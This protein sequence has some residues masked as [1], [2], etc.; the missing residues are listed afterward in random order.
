MANKFS[1]EEIELWICDKFSEEL[2]IDS[3]NVDINKPFSEYGLDSVFIVQMSG[4][5]EDFLELKIN[6]TTLFEYYTIEK[7]A[8]HFSNLKSNK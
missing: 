4:D 1:Y 5:L 6:P 7:L 3:D 2:K 8:T